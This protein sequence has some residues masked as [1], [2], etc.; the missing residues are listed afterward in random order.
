MRNTFRYPGGKRRITSWIIKNIPEHHSYLEPFFGGGAV[1]FSKEPSRIETVNDLDSEVVNLFKMIREQ[2]DEL[3]ERIVYTP[4]AR[5]VYDESFE[6]QPKDNV[7]RA[8]HF[9]IQSQQGYGYRLCEKTGW[10]RDVYGREAAYAVRYWNDLPETITEI[11]TRLKYVQ[12]ENRP[13]VDLIRT[14][15]H[16]NVLIYADP[17]YV[18]STRNRKQYRHEMSDEDHEKLLFT[19]L[20]SK[21]KVMLSGYDNALYQKYLHDWRKEQIPARAENCALRTETLW[22]NF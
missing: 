13:A 3:I 9:I 8:V 18:L 10:K 4:Y 14:F 20:E 1:L 19:L 12:I 22:M 17:P 15:N 21:A 5:E 11:A 6:K 16:E 2:K 7:E